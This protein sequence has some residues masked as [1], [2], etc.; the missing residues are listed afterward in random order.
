MTKKEIFSP[1][2]GLTGGILIGTI[3]GATAALLS[4]PKARKAIKNQLCTLSENA[5]DFANGMAE[6]SGVVTQGISDHFFNKKAAHNQQLNLLIG[7]IAGGILGISAA[8]LLSSESAKGACYSLVQGFDTVAQKTKE[9]GENIE[10]KTHDVVENVEDRIC[11][12]VKVAQKFLNNVNGNSSKAK[13]FGK[14]EGDTFDSV[15]NWALLGIRL[16]QGLKK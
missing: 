9:L 14:K 16:F 8:V 5:Q 11:S 2:N 1:T 3:V 4:N 6:K 15:L 10:E 7:S 12:W 13:A